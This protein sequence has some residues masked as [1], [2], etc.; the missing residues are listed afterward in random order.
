MEE[1]EVP[2][3]AQ[4][5]VLAQNEASQIEGLRAALSILAVM[6]VIALFFTGRIPKKRPGSEPKPA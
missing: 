6:G 3:D 2:A 1:A 4:D 5:D